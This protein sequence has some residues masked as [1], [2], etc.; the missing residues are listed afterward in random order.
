MEQYNFDV[1]EGMDLMVFERCRG[2]YDSEM[3]ED[4]GTGLAHACQTTLSYPQGGWT[5]W[6]L[7]HWLTSS[8][9]KFLFLPRLCLRMFGVAA[10]F[11]I[12]GVYFWRD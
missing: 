9:K 7:I 4:E 2:P 12:M 6:I 3:L 11:M 10:E 1:P 8:K 5:R